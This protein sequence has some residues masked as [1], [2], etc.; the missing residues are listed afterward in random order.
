MCVCGPVG[1]KVNITPLSAMN[2]DYAR[3]VTGGE[4]LTI[5]QKKQ[6]QEQQQVTLSSKTERYLT[7]KI[8]YPCIE[9]SFAVFMPKSSF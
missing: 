9:I 8:F 4:N 6:I 2:E 7:R 1:I 5:E 3:K